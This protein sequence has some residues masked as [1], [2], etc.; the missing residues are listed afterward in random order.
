MARGWRYTKSLI[1]CSF[2]IFILYNIVLFHV[3][4][5][6][7]LSFLFFVFILS[8]ELC[9]SDVALFFPC[10]ADPCIGWV[11]ASIATGYG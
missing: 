8:L 4:V 1:D 5:P 9:R 11:T 2:S 10:A 7:F 6:F 3:I